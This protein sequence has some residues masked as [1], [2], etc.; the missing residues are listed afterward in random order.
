MPKWLRVPPR[1]KEK[2]PWLKS[3]PQRASQALPDVLST[4]MH[5]LKE[6]AD[7]NPLLKSAVSAA[8]AVWDIAER[9]KRSKADARNIAL[10]A[11][12]ILK[13]VVIALP[14]DSKV[15]PPMVQSIEHF[16]VLLDGIWHQMEKMALTSRFSRVIHLNRNEG[17]LS[18]IKAEL[19]DA[20][21]DM[22]VRR[23]ISLPF[24][25]VCAAA[26]VT[27]SAT[28]SAASG[29]RSVANGAGS[30]AGTDARRRQEGCRVNGD[31][32]VSF[33][34]H[35]FFGQPLTCWVADVECA[36]AIVGM[37]NSILDSRRKP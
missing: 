26:R 8:L 3:L 24:C 7:F 14:V 25:C 1:G 22:L 37:A 21:R 17:V 33:Q 2:P 30:T 6:S 16:T 5:A 4:S 13:V 31:P 28:R 18:A 15:P 10:R 19:E 36:P 12:A 11:E 35:R 32:P 23:A 20:Y 29:A 27:T 34:F 9:A